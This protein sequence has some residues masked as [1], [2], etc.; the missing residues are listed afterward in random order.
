[1]QR[2]SKLLL[3]FVLVF[4]IFAS[5]NLTVF[6]DTIAE[7]QT[8]GVTVYNDIFPETKIKYGEATAH[9]LCHKHGNGKGYAYHESGFPV[10]AV[11][12][13]RFEQAH[14]AQ[15]NAAQNRNAKFLP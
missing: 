2:M 6:A 5:L 13:N 9:R 7:K 14:N 12:I 15:R 4:G 10:G 11:D 1:M 3:C 8:L